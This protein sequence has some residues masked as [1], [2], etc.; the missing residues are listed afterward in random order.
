MLEEVLKQR[1]KTVL[2]NQNNVDEPCKVSLKGTLECGYF[3]L[4][5]IYLRE[6]EIQN[7]INSTSI[8]LRWKSIQKKERKSKGLTDCLHV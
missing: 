4:M 3:K 1:F 5:Q 8:I 6:K 2:R 7:P